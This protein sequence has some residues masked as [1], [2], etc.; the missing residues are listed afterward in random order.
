MK[1]KLVENKEDLVLVEVE[2]DSDVDKVTQRHFKGNE[3]YIKI[4]KGAMNELVVY[5]KD[6]NVLK[7]DTF[8]E[9]SGSI[10][11]GTIQGMY[12]QL[13]RYLYKEGVHIGKRENY[14]E[15]KLRIMPSQRGLGKEG[16]YC[17]HLG[18]QFAAFLETEDEIKEMF[19]DYK[20]HDEYRAVTGVMVYEA[21]ILR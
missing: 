18:G 10:K 16:H 6:G 17:V 2:F 1:I 5:D 21:E 14:L 3:R 9:N 8:R 12:K 11:M 13:V 19:G 7:S 15:T 4:T 20:I